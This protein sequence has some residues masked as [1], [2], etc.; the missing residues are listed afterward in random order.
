MREL[1]AYRPGSRTRSVQC[2]TP[3][4]RAA[5]TI[6]TLNAI[7]PTRCAEKMRLGYTIGSITCDYVGSLLRGSLLRRS[8]FV[9]E[10]LR[11]SL[12]TGL[13][14]PTQW[15]MMMMMMMVAVKPVVRGVPGT[16]VGNSMRECRHVGFAVLVEYIR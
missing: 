10:N 6:P 9:S 2:P 8:L 13:C 12:P 1:E 3:S 14:E 15:M 5:Q 4:D 16:Y 7:R 11:G